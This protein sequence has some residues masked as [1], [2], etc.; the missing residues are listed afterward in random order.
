M[1]YA[2]LLLGLCACKPNLRGWWDLQTWKVGEEITRRD[3]GFLLWEEPSLDY[4]TLFLLLRYR[5]DPETSDLIPDPE[6]E[7]QERDWA[8]M[9]WERDLPIEV[10][11]LDENQDSVGL[12]MQLVKYTT[13]RMVL[14]GESPYGD[15]LTW[16][17]K[18][19]K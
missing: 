19:R 12:S 9:E 6:P 2:W 15:G 16:S 4:G 8:F 13:S 7:L 1:R 14:E 11:L 18:L 17:W 10:P 3:A 5:W